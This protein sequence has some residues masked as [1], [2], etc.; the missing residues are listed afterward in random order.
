MAKQKELG[1]I[2]DK[3]VEQIGASNAICLYNKY[4]IAVQTKHKDYDV[5]KYLNVCDRFMRY[6]INRYNIDK[7]MDLI[8]LDINYE[9]G[10]YKDFTKKV[11]KWNS[12]N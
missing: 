10:I 7:S 8:E 4:A 12:K 6:T 11:L 2:I 1:D 9:L 5:E 3:Y